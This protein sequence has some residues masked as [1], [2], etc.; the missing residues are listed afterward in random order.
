MLICPVVGDTTRPRRG[1]ILSPEMDPRRAWLDIP[2]DRSARKKLHPT[3]RVWFPASEA[4]LCRSRCSFL[5]FLYD[6]GRSASVRRSRQRSQLTPA[7]PCAA[8]TYL[9]CSPETWHVSVIPATSAPEPRHAGDRV[10]WRPANSSICRPPAITSGYDDL[11]GGV[12]APHY[13]S[14]SDRAAR[15]GTAVSLWWRDTGQTSAFIRTRADWL[16]RCSVPASFSLSSG[17]HGGG[18]TRAR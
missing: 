2:T 18:T 17:P 7:G 11:A 16:C 1:V 6:R 13:R 5:P 8:R 4:S 3:R 15:H 10:E 14:A 12:C 9:C